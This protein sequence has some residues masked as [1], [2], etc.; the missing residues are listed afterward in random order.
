MTF[1]VFFSHEGTFKPHWVCI[2]GAYVV[3][4]NFSICPTGFDIWIFSRTPWNRKVLFLF[5]QKTKAQKW[6]RTQI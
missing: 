1:S 5:K 2:L 6:N 3:F 4:S